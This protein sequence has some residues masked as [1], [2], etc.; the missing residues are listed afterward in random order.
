MVHVLESGTSKVQIS[1]LNQTEVVAGVTTRVVEERDW[2]NGSLSEV[3]RNFFVEAPDGTVCYYGEEVDE[4]Q[5][6]QIVAHSGSWRADTGQN[7]PGIIMPSHPAAGQ[8]Y[9]QEFAPGVA[10]DHAEHVA[11]NQVLTTPIGTFNE[12][13]VVQETP[14]SEKRYQRG[15]GLI[16][17]DGALLTKY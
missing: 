15:I 16:F 2:K 11:I 17:D 6:G 3:A 8:K 13:L 14:S 7:K 12:V 9:Q 5:G 4:Y 10:M 1:V